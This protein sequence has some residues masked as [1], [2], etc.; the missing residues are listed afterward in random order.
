MKIIKMVLIAVILV[1]AYLLFL[2]WQMDYGAQSIPSNQ[3]ALSG[4]NGANLSTSDAKDQTTTIDNL[5][6]N[7]DDTSAN[8][9]L[10]AVPGA[11][12]VRTASAATAKKTIAIETDTIQAKIQ[13]EGG[14]I[15][16]LALKD[17]Q[18]TLNNPQPLVL[19]DDQA[20]IYTMQSGL[21]GPDGTDQQAQLPIYTAQTDSY[22]LQP[23]EDSLEVM[24]SYRTAD[25]L[26]VDKIY[27]FT[28]NSHLIDLRYRI[29]NTGNQVK[30]INLYGQIKHDGRAHH[31]PTSAFGIKP[32]L[33]GALTTSEDHYQK[34]SF[35]DMQDTNLRKQVQGGWIALVQHY[36]VGSWIPDKEDTYWYQTRVTANNDYI[37]GFVGPQKQMQPGQELFLSAD[38]YAGPKKHKILSAISDHLELT[39]DYGWLWFISQPLFWLLHWIHDYVGNWG[40]SI[41]LL[42]L[43]IKL[44]F[45]HL[46]ATSYKSMAKMRQLG[47]K[48]TRLREQH[49]NDRQAFSKEMMAIY[50]KEKINPLGGC[51]PIVVQ[52]PVFIALYWTLLESVELR[53]APFIFWIQDLAVMDPYF[54]LP[55]LMG[56]SMFLQQQL[57]PT[58]MGDPIQ[59]KIMKFLP[60]IFT[61]FFLWFPAGLVLYWLVNNILS[62]A[63]QWVITRQI[64][65]Q[66]AKKGARA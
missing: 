10:S 17:F 16:H 25:G 63:Q 37:L 33:G 45:F 44:C 23:G 31:E 22:R 27:R 58:P 54:I 55:I 30:S 46:S 40:W 64:E 43:F 65:K 4:Q 21:I 5:D 26:A 20:F 8:V 57:S 56:A 29:K 19:M 62:I 48:L 51:L 12:S 24:L 38:F 59:V 66:A 49:G 2:Q 28:R 3:N 11:A 7:A 53:H 13:L 42:T 39:V 9:L 41:V 61:V 14:N 47:P 6:A 60:L 52:M 34:I 1:A 50:K 18:K 15:V 32:Y 35:A 36:F